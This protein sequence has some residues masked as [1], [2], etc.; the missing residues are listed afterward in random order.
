MMCNYRLGAKLMD[1]G[2]DSQLGRWSW[3]KFRGR[4]GTKVLIITAYQ[5]SQTSAQGLGM[6]TVYMQHRRKLANSNATVNP[7]AQ[8][9]ADLTMFIQTATAA[10]TEV[11]VMM[12]ANA[13]TTDAGF[14][15]FL[16]ACG[17]HDLHTDGDV[18]PPPE[19]YY[20]GKKK[21]DFCL[22]TH[23]AAYAVT[24]AEIT[25]YEGGLKYSDHRT[26]FVD[27]SEELS[28]TSK[29]VDPTAHKGRG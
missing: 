23:G 28:F 9:W 5:V 22:D 10:H 21:I 27:I 4:Q 24:R 25:S 8:F 3:M 15:D 20:R 7:R 16:I 19:A 29:E 1:K 17:L 26:L 13:D 18:D 14:A 11:L 2:C 6:D 12:D